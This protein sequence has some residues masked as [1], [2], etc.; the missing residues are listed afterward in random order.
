MYPETIEKIRQLGLKRYPEMNERRV[1]SQAGRDLIALGFAALEAG[2]VP[3]EP[4]PKKRLA[5]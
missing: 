1:M 3:G 5:P 4:I 2:F